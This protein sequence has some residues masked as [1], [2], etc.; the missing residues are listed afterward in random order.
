MRQSIN[1]DIGKMNRK[2]GVGRGHCNGDSTHNQTMGGNLYEF[3]I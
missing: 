3:V 2:S 1:K